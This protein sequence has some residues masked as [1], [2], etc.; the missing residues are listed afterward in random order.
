MKNALI[1]IDVQNDYF[2]GGAWPQ[3]QAAETAARIA[4]CVRA[5]DAAGWTVV[6]VRHVNAADAPMLAAGSAG[7]AF[8]P[9]IALLLVGRATLD[10]RAADAFWQTDLAQ[11]L[12]AAGVSDIYLCGMMT[13]NCIT[14]TALSPDAAAWRVHI[15]ADACTAPDARIHAVATR[16]L[17]ARLDVVSAVGFQAALGVV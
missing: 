11:V 15:I 4:G 5:A 9:A 14:H 17:S 6:A 16:A 1:V 7:A 2:A 3:F 10:K 8:Y 13:Q 12:A